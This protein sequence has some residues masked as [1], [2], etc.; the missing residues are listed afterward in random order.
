MKNFRITYLLKL[1][2]LISI[3]FNSYLFA[4]S[5][6]QN[7]DPD[8]KI[9]A[10]KFVKAEL[11][12][13]IHHT[14]SGPYSYGWEGGLYHN[15]LSFLEWNNELA[16]TAKKW[17]YDMARLD[18]FIRKKDMKKTFT[19]Q[20]ANN[21]GIQKFNDVLA[22]FSIQVDSFEIEKIL[23]KDNF[24][25]HGRHLFGMQKSH[26]LIGIGLVK[27]NQKYYCCILTAFKDTNTINR[28]TINEQ[29]KKI[30][31]GNKKIIQMADSLFGQR[32][33]DGK[34]HR[35]C[36]GWCGCFTVFVN[37]NFYKYGEIKIKKYFFPG[38][39]NIYPGDHI[40]FKRGVRIAIPAILDKEVK[41]KFK[42]PHVAFIH[43]KINE[44][45]YALIHQ[46]KY[47]KGVYI[48]VLQL[49]YM[50]RG[51]I[52]ITRPVSNNYFESFINTVCK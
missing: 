50:E 4:Q 17:A 10:H 34:V 41:I 24:G 35:V 38:I 25:G 18:Y 37:N 44:F 46:D 14:R 48:S 39:Y 42:K 8:I 26:Y 11:L 30:P 27:A 43:H 45:T 33:C 5:I 3:L 16:D 21:E 13:G 29:F 32:V 31:V 19:I 9:Y 22:S 23:K 2:I 36:P 20:L 12:F 49:G 47:S 15:Y 40:Y 6:I 28:T 51:K 1:I 7:N 52:Y